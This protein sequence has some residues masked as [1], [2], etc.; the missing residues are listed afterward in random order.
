VELAVVLDGLLDR[1]DTVTPAGP[2][3][4]TGSSVIAGLRRVPVSFG[5]S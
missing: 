2:V 1:F 4:R 5:R 3:E